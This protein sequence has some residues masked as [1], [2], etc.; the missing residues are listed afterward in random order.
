MVTGHAVGVFKHVLGIQTLSILNHQLAFCPPSFYGLCSMIKLTKEQENALKVVK[1]LP[2]KY[3]QEYVKQVCTP[4]T[5][6]SA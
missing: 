4:S 1:A 5:S 2:E 6:D 3:I